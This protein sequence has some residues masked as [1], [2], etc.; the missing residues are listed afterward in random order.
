MQILLLVLLG[1]CSVHDLRSR[2]IPAVFIWICIGAAS[3]YRIH[4]MVLGKSNI[5]ECL[6]C[7]IPGLVLLFFSYVGRQVGS[8]DGWLVIA[9]GLCLK[10]EA[11]V[12][13]L[14]YA[15]VAAGLFS[16]GYLLF[17]HREKTVG[18]P[19]VPFLFGGILFFVLGDIL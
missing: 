4:M 2:K 14:I 9:S 5:K 17:T 19:F 18:I 16:A 6:L 8:G 7:I 3:V 10:W 13:A 11:L 1:I 12:S 15:F